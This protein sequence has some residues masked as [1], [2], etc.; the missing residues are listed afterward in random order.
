MYPTQNIMMGCLSEPR[1]FDVSNHGGRG[2][3]GVVSDCGRC[4][5]LSV[6]RVIPHRP[7]ARLLAAT[8]QT[9]FLLGAR[10]STSSDVFRENVS[11]GCQQDVWCTIRNS[12]PIIKL[13]NWNYLVGLCHSACT[14]CVCPCV[15]LLASF[16]PLFTFSESL[17]LQPNL[18]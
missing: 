18:V 1:I 14:T 6:T 13:R 5:G 9:R 11:I 4:A 15:H 10:E 3:S 8:G 7:C 12:S 17:K 2:S 16:F